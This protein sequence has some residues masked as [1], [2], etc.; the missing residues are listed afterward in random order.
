M[1]RKERILAYMH[2]EFYVPLKFDELMA[3]LSVP[4]EDAD[5]LQAILDSLI[6]E[7]R[8][9]LTKKGR[10]MSSGVGASA[11]AGKLRANANGFFGFVVCDNPDDGD[12]IYIHGSNMLDALDSDRVLVR[13]D[14]HEIGA[15]REGKVIKVLERNTKAIVGVITKKK[16][17]CYRVEPDNKRIYAAVRVSPDNMRGA[18]IGDRVHVQLTEI[19]P[20]GKFYGKVLAVLG[21]AGSLKSLIE[22]IIIS[23][24]I[25][26]EFDPDTLAEAERIPD[27]VTD[28][29]LRDREDLRDLLTFTIDGADA[30]DFD[31]AVSLEMLQNGH[32]LLGVHIA[33]V[34]HYV[35]NHMPLDREASKRATSVYLADRVIPMLP[36]K[37]SNGICS[38]NP[39][40][41]RLTLSVIMEI[42][43]TGRVIGHELKK[44]V[45][46]SKERLV[47]SDV[48]K[49]LENE[50][51]PETKALLEK[52]EY[53]MPTL[54]N[55]ERLAKILTDMR[56]KRG[57]LGFDFHETY[58]KVDENG[59][60]VDIL[61]YEKGIS[62]KI[63][64]EFMLTAN[65]TIAEYAYWSELPF[66]YRVHDAPSV[67]KISAFNAFI[68]N[69]NLSI[70]GK[71]DDEPIHPT[72]LQAILDKI[73]D[74]P[75]EKMI[76][77]EM[78]RS[79]MKAEYSHENR[80]HFG[81]AA[82]YYCHFTSPIRRY[83]DL[84]IHRILKMF[85][86]GKL[87]DNKYEL[88]AERVKKEAA[89]SSEKERT[90]ELAERDT[91]DLMKAAYM[92]NFVGESFEAT[93]SSVTSFGMFVELD[94]SVEGLIR[95][96]NMRADYFVY[97][98]L[99]GTLTGERTGQFYRIGDRVAVTL[100]RSDMETRMIDFVLE[101]DA[102]PGIYRKF[103]GGRS[104]KKKRD[105][106]A[107]KGEK[108]KLGAAKAGKPFKS[109]K[110]DKKKKKKKDI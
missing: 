71:L 4:K 89:N 8:I 57:A 30:R 49:L 78:L 110:K 66:V 44:A 16:D 69:F 101:E 105:N 25:K 55:M 93:V 61:P 52:Y 33:D 28:K 11:V 39:H 98:E 85:I 18:I 88:L 34:T 75:E 41:D 2:S 12:D 37:L 42:D 10:Y 106:G 73:K 64:E 65:E 22:G 109:G 24:G 45:I 40:V 82:K 36:T 103:N 70:K 35:K 43:Q 6:T 67:D 60:P 74:T 21:T 84:M 58:I 15:R 1:D 81:L 91:D 51:T 76:A 94:N 23:A 9:V 54:R 77:T 72:A 100:V 46:C 17:G 3:V 56:S 62:N 90:A 87:V 83:P 59:E 97:D 7:G 99:T 26:Q 5:E 107:K 79:L 96:E 48:T 14:T 29:D 19:T 68:R 86:E 32:Y 108:K 53:L 102:Y 31:D 20:Q 63:I 38:L 92:N 104:V 13:I 80:G 27:R 95:L 47:Y 50:D